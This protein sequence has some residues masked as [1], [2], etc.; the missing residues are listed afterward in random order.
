[1]QRSILEYLEET[2]RRLPEKT[3]FAGETRAMTFRQVHDQARAIGSWLLA[4]KLTGPVAVFMGRCPRTITAFL[5]TI[6]AGCFYVPLDPEMPRVRIQAILEKTRP[7]AMI[8][9]GDT[10]ALAQGLL[11]GKWVAYETA[12]F[13]I[14]D[15][16]RLKAVRASALDIDPIYTVF[17]SGSTG[18]PK[19]V[20]GTHRAALDYIE[21]LCPVLGF[22]EDTVFGNQTPLYYDA[23]LKEIL[24]TL[25]FGATT[26]LIP[27]KLF[28]FPVD[29]V[30]YLNQHKINTLCWVVSALTMISSMGT[31]Q[32]LKPKTLRTVAFASEVFPIRQLNLWRQA[33][34]EARFFNL[35][36]PTETT[37]ICC[38]YEVDRDFSEGEVL[39]VGKPFPNTGI[40]LLN[41]E[42]KVPGSGELGEICI[43]GTRLT[44][45][46][47]QDPER[48]EAAFPQNPLNP[49]FR[50]RIY[51]TGDLG[52][53][54]ARGELEFLGRKDQQVKV[55]GHRVELGE[56]EAAA[57]TCGEL[58]G[59][60]CVYDGKR[61]VLFYAG[62][63]AEQDLAGQIRKLLPR[64]MVPGVI[65]RLTALP[66]TPNGKI[67]RTRLRALV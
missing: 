43:R 46:Y 8:C 48:T 64:Y 50:E 28:L 66:M 31:F 21:N 52:R 41:E 10:R 35:Y 58:Q 62:D 13:G 1:M 27:Q 18:V 14:I 61:L 15:E 11:P 55:M 23:C 2:V 29:L 34:P 40:V 63:T 20:L 32:R 19:G 59:S 39:P 5:G 36:G 38:Y 65:R 26:W 7:A 51:R 60:C 4:R 49:H 22:G 30:M 56:I 16:E 25:K 42:N 54:N 67:D 24:P 44:L 47:Y 9:D 6:Y 3:A 12:A 57:Q 37:G 53:F 45:G 33:L 17:T